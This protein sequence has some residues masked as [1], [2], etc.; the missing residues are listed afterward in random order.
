MVE[1]IKPPAAVEDAG[2]DVLTFAHVIG[3]PPSQT[4]HSIQLCPTEAAVVN[5]KAARAALDAEIV[6]ID[7]EIVE[8]QLRIARYRA[9][10]LEAD[11]AVRLAKQAL[12]EVNVTDANDAMRIGVDR[13]CTSQAHVR[14]S[15]ADLAAAGARKRDADVELAAAVADEVSLRCLQAQAV[16]EL[17]ACRLQVQAVQ[18]PSAE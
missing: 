14:S 10:R 18:S 2:V 9:L 12:A 13:V 17:S 5:A 16:Q 3:T 8:I 6:E 15:D 11:L 7:A 4:P 1:S